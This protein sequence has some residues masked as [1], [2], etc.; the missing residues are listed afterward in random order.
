MLGFLEGAAVFQ[1][2]FHTR[3]HQT[4]LAFMYQPRTGQSFAQKVRLLPV[5]SDDYST[6]SEA[7]GCYRQL[8]AVFFNFGSLRVASGRFARGTVMRGR[9]FLCKATGQ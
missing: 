9:Y 1:G 4:A 8:S 2:T 6:A 5:S 3:H 7:T